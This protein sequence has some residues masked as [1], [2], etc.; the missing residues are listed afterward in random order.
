MTDNQSRPNSITCLHTRYNLDVK[1]KLVEMTWGKKTEMP[2]SRIASPIA[3]PRMTLEW[4]T[5]RNVQ[6]SFFFFFF[7]FKY[8]R[9]NVITRATFKASS[10]GCCTI[11]N[12]QLLSPSGRR[13]EKAEDE[14]HV[15]ASSVDGAPKG[16]GETLWVCFGPSF[17]LRVW[18]V[19]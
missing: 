4:K 11:T 1:S 8:S 3:Q 5:K 19:R 15:K 7:L 18:M 16:W 12:N 6:T 14:F 17:T 9:E 2:F 13:R 10:A